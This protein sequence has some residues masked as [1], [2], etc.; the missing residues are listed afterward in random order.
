M[1]SRLKNFLDLISVSS[2][3]P[4]LKPPQYGSFAAESPIH[5][6]PMKLAGMIEDILSTGMKTRTIILNFDFV[7]PPNKVGEHLRLNADAKVLRIERVRLIK[8][9]PISYSISYI[10]SDLGEKVSVRDL[11][12]QPLLNVLEDKCKMKI[13]RGSQVIEATVADSRVASFLEVL[14]GSPLLKMERVVFDT[15]NRP[16]EYISILYRSDRYHY[17]VDFIRRGSEAEIRWGDLKP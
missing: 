6:K 12:V 1:I 17:N 4:S 2:F 13:V 5:L 15:R 16:I 3:I 14:T 10:P 11:M 8:G 7:Y 9:Q